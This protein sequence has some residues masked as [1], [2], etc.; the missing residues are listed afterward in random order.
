M[1][2]CVCSILSLL[3]SSNEID[4]LPKL[5]WGTK[6]SWINFGHTT[7]LQNEYLWLLGSTLFPLFSES[8]HLLILFVCLFFWFFSY[9]TWI[10][11]SIE[12]VLHLDTITMAIRMLINWYLHTYQY[13]AWKIYSPFH[14]V[15]FFSTVS[16]IPLIFRMNCIVEET[17]SVSHEQHLAL[18]L[19]QLVLTL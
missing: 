6:F 11:Y 4:F 7:N 17:R 2:S 13:F 12:F 3:Y 14:L 1:T 10:A 5:K 18:H 16:V 15:Y 19:S 8:D 9:F